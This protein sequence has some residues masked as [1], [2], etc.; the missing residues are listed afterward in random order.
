MSQRE[1]IDELAYEAWQL[2]ECPTK[3]SLFEEAVR[4]ADLLGDIDLGYE[5]REGLIR[6]ATF[7]GRNDVQMVAFAWCIAQFDRYPGRFDESDLLWKYKW[8]VGNAAESPDYS[9]G[10]IEALL[11]DMERRF[12][13]AGHSLHAVHQHRRQNMVEMRDRAAAE[14][15]QAAFLASRR[16]R[17]SDCAACVA[18]N[19]GEYHDYC[20]QY[21]QAWAAFR[22]VTDGKL[23][24]QEEPLRCLSYA[25]LPLLRLGQVDQARKLR[26]EAQRLLAKTGSAVRPAAAQITFL[27]IV[28]DLAPARYLVRR[29]LPEGLT[30][31]SLRD[32]LAMIKA[33]ILALMQ[34]Q[35]AGVRDFDVPRPP[36][37]P[38]PSRCLDEA[39]AWLREEARA[40]SARFDARNG[41]DEHLRELES[42]PQL[43]ELAAM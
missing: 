40:I 39:L 42:L 27:A 25:L 23:L 31:V 38:H 16:D 20:G 24:C 14:R 15:A 10:Q 21:D 1:R 18:C 36:A 17:L 43:L 22:T 11:D 35:A 5:L 32:R 8:I 29:Y 26:K 28:E 7:T 30:S 4:L 33:A 19:T 37:G 9:R 2:P 12:L 34:L 6:T 13:A 41:N 3:L